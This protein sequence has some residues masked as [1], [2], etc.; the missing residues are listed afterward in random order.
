VSK[1]WPTKT[2]LIPPTPPAK[3]FLI[4]DTL[5]DSP[6]FVICLLSLRA[7]LKP[8]KILIYIEKKSIKNNSQN[9]V[10]WKHGN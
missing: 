2:V 10:Q 5:L 4:G 9:T 6:I 3:K 1:G 8:L 7:Y